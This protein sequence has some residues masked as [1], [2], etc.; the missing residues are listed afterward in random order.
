M[1]S[2]HPHPA[3]GRTRQLI[4]NP[5]VERRPPTKM[6]GPLCGFHLRAA[7]LAEVGHSVT[8]GVC[9][10]RS[11]AALLR[12]QG[13]RREGLVRRRELP[14]KPGP[15]HTQSQHSPRAAG[16]PNTARQRTR[17]HSYR[18]VVRST[19]L[20][21]SRPRTRRSLPPLPATPTCIAASSEKSN[22][23]LDG[24]V[25]EIWP[26]KRRQPVGPTETCR[27]S[28]FLVTQTRVFFHSARRPQSARTGE[29]ASLPT[30]RARRRH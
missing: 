11:R 24:N 20:A 18:L 17:L 21:Q 8:L 22:E 4:S 7:G 1:S 30:A 23:R 10:G 9:S 6:K 15:S 3:T 16:R 12:R 25:S 28:A 14:M 2:A 26:C 5:A 29:I 27:L 19:R 13:G